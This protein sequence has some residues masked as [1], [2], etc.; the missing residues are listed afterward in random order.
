M[1]TKTR[2]FKIFLFFL[3]AILILGLLLP[4]SQ[5]IPVEG[6]SKN[7]WHP[8]TFWFEPWG[9]SGVHKGIDIFA[10]NGTPVAASTGGLVM[11][12]GEWPMG[13]RVVLVLGPKWRIHY[14]AHLSE[15]PLTD[16]FWVSQGDR[17]GGVGATGN[18]IGKAPHLHYSVVTLLP[19]FWLMS[20]ETQGW[21]KAFFLNPEDYFSN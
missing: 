21:K 5:Q 4:G 17:L 1:P 9:R 13:G 11:F 2:A 14:Y 7:D 15:D 16:Q 3:L 10:D 18:A 19:Y 8:D 12:A 20:S 6:A